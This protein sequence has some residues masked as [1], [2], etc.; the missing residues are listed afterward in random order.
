M[1]KRSIISLCRHDDITRNYFHEYAE[2]MGFNVDFCPLVSRTEK[3]VV[4]AAKGYSAIIA[5]VE[6]YTREVFK[7]LSPELK[8]VHRF[9]VGY[10]NIDVEAARDFDIAV[11]IASGGN[12]AAVADHAIMLMLA[13]GRRIH[14]YDRATRRGEW[15]QR[16]YSQLSG[17]KVGLIGFG[18][19]GRILCGLL[20]GFRCDILV[21]DAY[22][23]DDVFEE[24]GIRRAE[25]NEIA[26]ECDFVSLH[27]PLTEETRGLIGMNF[28]KQMKSSAFL[29]NTSRG[30]IVRE[31]DLVL[32]LR[33]GLI[34][35]AGLDVFEKEPID[36]DN[37]LKEMDNVIL[38]PHIAFSTLEANRLTSEIII[39]NLQ[40]FFDG[41]PCRDIVN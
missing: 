18:R 16:P 7:A 15:I 27:V 32:A 13:L 5:S 21:N 31:A 8:A 17:K 38:S 14:L 10:D 23:S 29:I 24:Y 30:P 12:A 37:P 1:D 25:M 33:E 40:S 28:L 36:A 19:I 20:S 2:S 34:A 3:D 4:E 11:M 26:S 41:R 9:G 22:I 35:G 6:P 39:N